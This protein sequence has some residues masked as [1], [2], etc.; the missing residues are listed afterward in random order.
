MAGRSPHRLRLRTRS[1]PGP[2]PAGYPD[3]AVPAYRERLSKKRAQRSWAGKS[4]MVNLCCRSHGA[5]DEDGGI[6]GPI[7]GG[8]LEGERS[9]VER[10]FSPPCQRK[11]LA[12]DA[13]C[14]SRSG[15]TS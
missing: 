3:K 1:D 7:S 6:I 12:R 14:L 4:V 10:P 11:Q 13:Q 5:Q 8:G 2:E 15:M 9:I